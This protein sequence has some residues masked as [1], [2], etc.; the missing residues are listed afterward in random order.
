MS[1]LGTRERRT[2]A[3]TAAPHGHWRE[4][5][6]EVGG[7][8][9]LSRLDGREI[10]RRVWHISPGFLPFILWR[11]PH[12]DPASPTLL[13]IV[14]GTTIVLGTL[15]FLHFHRI[16]R[17]GEANNS[18]VGAVLGYAG[19][20]VT[21]LLLFPAQ[22]ELSLTVLAILAFGDGSATLGGK[23]FGGSKLPWNREKTWS[24][25]CCFL[26]AGLTM[27][28]IIYWGEPYHNPQSLSP[29]VSPLIG[30]LCAGTGVLFA[31]VAESI[32]SRINDNVR[33][34]VAA[35]TGLLLAHAVLVGF[36]Y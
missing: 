21:M 5:R 23:L 14:T 4:L 13:A 33:V 17:R 18:R 22:A 1:T 20:I 6:K 2:F 25:L 3:R 29:P 8:S 24:G 9:V 34:G 32:P 36:S 35:A 28:T 12:S 10:L 16:S 11:I 15:I 27:G 30:M 19:S 26:M 7:E 31:A